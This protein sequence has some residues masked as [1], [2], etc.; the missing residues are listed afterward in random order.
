MIH[1]LSHYIHLHNGLVIHY[2]AQSAVSID[3]AG[4]ASASLWNKN[5]NSVIRVRFVDETE[6]IEKVSTI[7]LFLFPVLPLAFIVMS[8]Y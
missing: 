6:R 7:C 1:D 5:S 2:E 8:M 4:M 3:L